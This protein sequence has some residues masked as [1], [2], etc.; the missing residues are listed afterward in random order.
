MET[1]PPKLPKIFK[2][3]VLVSK[4][5]TD[6]SKMASKDNNNSNNKRQSVAA[7]SKEKDDFLDP[8]NN[9]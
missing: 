6:I 5:K 4:F 7:A 8:I 3:L 1:R 9:F 2:T